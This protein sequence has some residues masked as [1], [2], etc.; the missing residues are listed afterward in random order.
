LWKELN[1]TE[2]VI[3]AERQSDEKADRASEDRPAPDAAFVRALFDCY[4]E[5]FDEHLQSLNYCGPQTLRAAINR[6]MPGRSDLDIVDLG[7]GTGLSGLAFKS[8]ARHFTGVD[9][10]SR[11]LVRARRRKIYDRLVESDIVEALQTLPPPYDLIIAADVLIYMGGLED[12]FAEIKRILR[13]Q[14]CF[15]FTVEKSEKDGQDYL[16]QKSRRYAHSENYIRRLA[17]MNSLDVLS[18]EP[19]IMRREAQ[20][21]IEALAFVLQKRAWVIS[22]IP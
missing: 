9:F 5:S 10:S 18:A 1:Q 15:A 2:K 17:D 16:L 3:E 11:M 22:S 7:C 14:G 21:G 20:K 13:S 19:F 6:V 4:A 12:L 8:L